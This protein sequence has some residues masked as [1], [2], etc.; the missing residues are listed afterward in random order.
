MAHGDSMDQIAR[1][2]Q[3]LKLLHHPNFS[4]TEVKTTFGQ[5]R[6]DRTNFKL[7]VVLDFQ[8]RCHRNHDT[9]WRA[10]SKNHSPHVLKVDDFGHTIFYSVVWCRKENHRSGYIK[11]FDGAQGFGHSLCPTLWLGQ[12]D[13][14]PLRMLSLVHVGRRIFNLHHQLAHGVSTD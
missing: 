11:N 8:Q 7:K 14:R 10:R 2:K 3:Q 1:R 5:F 9:W 12:R 4:V 6:S 13:F